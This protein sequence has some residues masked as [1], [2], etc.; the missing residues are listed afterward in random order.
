MTPNVTYSTSGSTISLYIDLV[1]DKAGH[2]DLAAVVDWGDGKKTTIPRQAKVGDAVSV[3]VDHTVSSNGF[4]AIKVTGYNFGVPTADED[5]C[6]V[7]ITLKAPTVQ[8]VNRGFIRGPLLPESGKPWIIGSDVL[9]L[10][11]NVR[12]ILLT[13]KGERLMAPDFGTTLSQLVF[14]TNDDVL[15]PI[16]QSE[17][18]QAIKKWEPRVSVS[19]VS[20][21][22]D[23]TN[24]NVFCTILIKDR[25][26]TLGV[27]F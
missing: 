14:D 12:N 6:F 10:V 17:V 5:S 18:T 7:Y 19:S 11:S 27:T 22:R 23:G 2:T 16:V 15:V 24:L 25:A 1:D 3:Q 9:L 21:S 13:R 4:Y 26:I 20:L 8:E